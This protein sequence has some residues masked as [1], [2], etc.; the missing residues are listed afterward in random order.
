MIIRFRD[1]KRGELNLPLIYFIITTV[2]GVSGYVL[3]RFHSLPVMLCPFKELTGHPC[4][5]CGSTRLVLSLFQLDI[6]SAFR[7]NPGVFLAGLALSA[8]Y[9]VGLFQLVT[10]RVLT[11]HLA[12]WERRVVVW[13][14][15]ALFL[16]NWLYLW[17]TGV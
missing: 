3:F 16:L 4:P 8:W 5:T 11:V 6:P 13:T 1:R 15:V 2:L 17:V 9:G 12:S 10:G 14:L 7:V